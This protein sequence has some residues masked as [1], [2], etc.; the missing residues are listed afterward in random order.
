MS[1]AGMRFI[2]DQAQDHAIS[3]ALQAASAGD[4]AAAQRLAP[5]VYSQLRALAAAHMRRTPPGQTLQATALVHEAFLR[6]FQ[7]DDP[8]WESRRHFVGAAAQ[9]MRNILVD[10]ARAKAALKRGGE[11]RRLDI[12]DVEPAFEDMAEDILAVN[13]ALERLEAE[14]EH[15]SSVLRMRFFAGLSH[16]EIAAALGVS[17][18]T[19]ERDWRYLKA[20]LY[21][22]LGGSEPPAGA[23]ST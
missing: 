1:A 7:T 21:R 19:I 17:E 2:V 9:A 13:Q 16:A 22:E 8:Q 20:R 11:R 15:L 12:V 23:T 3:I 18:R 10:Q 4:A 6:L 14:D 5:L